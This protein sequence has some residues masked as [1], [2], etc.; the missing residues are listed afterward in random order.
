MNRKL[1][2]T[3]LKQYDSQAAFAKAIGEDDAR[4]SRVIR[5]WQSLTDE[6]RAKWAKALG[7]KEED[8]S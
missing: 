3:I 8:L 4:V 2:L 6:R 5:G 1:R 7:V